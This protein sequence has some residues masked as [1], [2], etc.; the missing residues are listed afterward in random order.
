MWR[1][2]PVP[3]LRDANWGGRWESLLRRNQTREALRAPQLEAGGKRLQ[4]IG[5]VGVQIPSFAHRSLVACVH[6]FHPESLVIHSRHAE[7][8]QEGNFGGRESDNRPIETY[9]SII[10]WCPRESWHR[11][12]TSHQ[13]SS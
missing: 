5:R 11:F 2:Q 4:H 12:L 7:Y 13:L 9:I 1:A 10:S 6:K 8:A 3:G